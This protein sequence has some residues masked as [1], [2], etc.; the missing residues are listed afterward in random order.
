MTTTPFVLMYGTSL[1]G[2]SE[3]GEVPAFVLVDGACLAARW[4]SEPCEVPV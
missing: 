2:R 3:A 4:R 1:R